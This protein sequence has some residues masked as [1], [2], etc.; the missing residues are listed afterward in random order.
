[1]KHNVIR[2][3]LCALTASCAFVGGAHSAEIACGT[4]YSVVG[5]DTLSKISL[6][7]YESLLYQ[8][9]YTANIDTIGPNPDRIFIG[10]SLSIPCLPSDSTVLSVSAEED[11]DSVEGRLVFT[12]NRASAPPFIINSGIVDAYLSDITEATDGRVTF[13]DPEEINRAH[14]D[15]FALVTSGQVDGAYVLNSTIAESHPLLQLPM[16]PMF[17][18]SAEQTAVSLWRLHDEYLAQTDYFD[19]AQLLGFIAAPAAHIWR[20]ASMPVASDE[21]IAVKNEYNVPYFMGL[22]TKGPAV[23]RADMTQRASAQTDTPPAYFMAHGAALATGLWNADTNVSVMEVDNGIY[24][25]TFSV[26]LSNDA[27]AQISAADQQAIQAISGEALAFRSAAW[28]EFDNAFRSRMLDQGLDFEKADKAL[29]D[30]LWQSSFAPLNAWI[31]DVESRG[32]PGSM[33]VNTYL[34]SLRSL[35]DRLI[36]RGEETFVDQ[37]PFVTAGN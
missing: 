26:I 11:A 9:I 33:A 20:D 3:S 4:S 1:M 35:E 16:L 5:G 13:I 15:Q 10:Q 23:M 37:H 25:P 22:D 32:V 30:N 31:S 2:A 28:D 18:G 14:A 24:T 7:S 34:M 36:Y 8:P 17:G 27:W 6:R 12:F 29:L 21:N 19:D